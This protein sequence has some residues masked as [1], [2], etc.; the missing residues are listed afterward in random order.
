MRSFPKIM[1]IAGFCLFLSG[2]KTQA[3]EIPVQGEG[4]AEISENFNEVQ[5]LARKNAIRQVVTMAVRKVLGSDAMDNPKVQQRFDE[6][7]SQFNVYKIKQSETSHREG[8]QYVTS[9]MAILD[10]K[11][12]QQTVSDLGVAINTAMVRSSA[13]LILMDEFFNIPSDLINPSPIREVTVL[14]YDHDI[15]STEKDTLSAKSSASKSSA[16]SSSD[17]GATSVKASSAGSL[18]AKN[19]EKGS[20]SAKNKESASYSGNSSANVHGR[21][22]SVSAAGQESAKYSQKGSMDAK[23]SQKGSIDA[24]NDDRYASDSKHDKRKAATSSSS[25]KESLDYRHFASASDNEHLFFS[26]VKEYQP[27]N[28]IPDKQ[29]FTL[30]AIQSS[31]QDSDIKIL[32]NDRF[33]SKFFKDQVVSIDMMENS[34]ELDKYVKFARDEAHADF[35]S[36][37]TANIVDRGMDPNSDKSVC[38]GMVTIKVYSTSDGEAIASGIMTE[39]ASGNSNDQCRT[40]VA[41]RIGKELGEVISKKIQEYWKKRQMYGREYTVL[42]SGEI[43]RSV[44]SQF[45]ASLSKVSGITNVVQRKSEPGMVEYVLSY[46]GQV[47]IGDAILDQMGANSSI[48]A[49]FNNYDAAVDGTL[50]KLFP[51]NQ[52]K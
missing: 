51:A 20:L 29:N 33:R 35:F 44:R 1:I 14:Q 3:V 52:K 16:K 21:D 23:Y 30:K 45:T 25:Q 13:I 28:G 26:N 15:D 9:V 7:V 41:G 19:E 4:R 36:I 32:D 50:V 2:V 40:T 46:N 22:G 8:N 6:I 27:K 43:P 11:I 34:A 38:D 37:G 49:T 24:R 10:D 17:I 12:F 39:S 18:Q 48:A 5:T 47:A 31:Y 42:L